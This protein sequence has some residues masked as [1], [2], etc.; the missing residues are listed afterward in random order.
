MKEGDPAT[1]VMGG[2]VD[3]ETKAVL[4]RAVG[5]DMIRVSSKTRDHLVTRNT[6]WELVDQ[7]NVITLAALAGCVAV[8]LQEELKVPVG[9]IVRS[10][11]G[12]ALIE[13]I[14]LEAFKADPLVKAT[15]EKQIAEKGKGGSPTET[16]GAKWQEYVAATVPY[17]IRGVLWD[18]GEWGVGFKGV[19]WTPAMHALLTTWRK[20]WGQGDFPWS[21]T[22]RYGKGNTLAESLAGHGIRGFMVTKN[23][24][25]TAGGLHPVNKEDFAQRHLD[26]ILPQVYGRPAPKWDRP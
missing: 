1:S 17:G 18:Q 26:N 7:T 21:A 10:E 22:D 2:K 3:G 19:G 11:S 6:G 20:T 9:I 4:R 25:V 8:H 24:P 23:P 12:T 13:W 16:P 14:G 5:N 15:I